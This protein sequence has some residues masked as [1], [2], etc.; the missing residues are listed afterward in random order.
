VVHFAQVVLGGGNA[1]WRGRASM[2]P[3]PVRTQRH[4]CAVMP[5]NEGGMGHPL[6]STKGTRATPFTSVGGSPVRLKQ[7]LG[8]IGD[9]VIDSALLV[10]D[11]E[12]LSRKWRR[13]PCLIPSSKTRS[14]TRPSGNP[15]GIGGSPTRGSPTRSS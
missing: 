11:D 3:D 1:R 5:S 14:S 15:T 13:W 10:C 12:R 6:S 4:R 7:V 9:Q 2:M 8:R